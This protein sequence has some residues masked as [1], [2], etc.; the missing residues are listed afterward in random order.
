MNYCKYTFFSEDTTEREILIAQLSETG[1]E[2]FEEDD[3]ALYAFIP[4]D[5]LDENA[6]RAIIN[7]SGINFTT[8]IIHKQNW[9]AQ[10]EADYEPVIIEGFC[11]V[12]AQFHDPADTPYEIIITPK[13]SFGTGHHATTKLMMQAMRDLEFAGKQVLDFGSGTGILAILAA[14]LGA[15]NV[16]AIDH[17]EW[18]VENAIEN[19]A[20]NGVTQVTVH[21]GSLE[22]AGDKTFDIILANINRHILL[23]YMGEMAAKLNAGGSL[24]LSGILKEDEAIITGEAAKSMLKFNK[25]L[26]WGNWIALLFN[27]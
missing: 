6:V 16:V 10:W 26:E 19:T 1:F 21:R 13:M 18:A 3:A 11:T 27:V 12:R 24:L 23:Q 7:D 9:N 22:E 8:E 4:V 15:A 17:E 5:E 14:K 25:K 2:A 20:L